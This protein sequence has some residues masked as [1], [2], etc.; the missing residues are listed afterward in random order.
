MVRGDKVSKNWTIDE[1]IHQYK[2]SGIA[3]Q[4]AT[5]IGD[6]KTNNKEG[7]KL[8]TIYKYLEKNTD[9]AISIFSVLLSDDNIVTRT[10]A[11]AHCLALNINIIKAE[12]VLEDAAND[13]STGIFGFNAKMVLKVW[14]E[15]GYI[16]MYN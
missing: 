15:Q 2:S 6:Y 7:K 5:L 1:I 12:Q 9:K 4:K 11:A 10:K 8:I 14:H 13:E 16:K 3:M